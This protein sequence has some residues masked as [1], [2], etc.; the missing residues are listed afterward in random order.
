MIEKVITDLS[1]S[2]QSDF[3]LNSGRIDDSQE[4]ARN[5]L[6]Q[7]EAADNQRSLRLLDDIEQPQDIEAAR[8][9]GEQSRVGQSN[10]STG[11]ELHSETSQDAFSRETRNQQNDFYT[12]TEEV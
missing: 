3:D 10:N 1:V 6:S 2:H 9:F 7:K 8:G 12:A 11:F 4:H 5:S